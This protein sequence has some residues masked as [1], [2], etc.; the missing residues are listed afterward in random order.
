MARQPDLQKGTVQNLQHNSTVC[1]GGHVLWI[2]K[3]TPTQGALDFAVEG[4]NKYKA[5]K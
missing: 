5:Q 4:A 2:P 1:E 3:D